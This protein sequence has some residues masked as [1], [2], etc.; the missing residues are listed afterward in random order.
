M[1]GIRLR[2][3]FGMSYH[4]REFLD[5]RVPIVTSDPL[6]QMYARSYA[7]NEATT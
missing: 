4:V 7:T 1:W 2:E 3:Q 6:F 5:S